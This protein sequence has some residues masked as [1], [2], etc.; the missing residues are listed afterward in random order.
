MV[1]WICVS[2]LSITRTMVHGKSYISQIFFWY[3]H[4]VAAVGVVVVSILHWSNSIHPFFQYAFIFNWM[5][6][7]TFLCSTSNYSSSCHCSCFLGFF[8]SIRCSYLKQNKFYPVLILWRGTL[9]ILYCSNAFS[10]PTN[11]VLRCT[12]W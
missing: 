6:I 1:R 9:E 3:L 2:C 12:R 10:F 5:Q 8:D 4:A 11:E 7:F